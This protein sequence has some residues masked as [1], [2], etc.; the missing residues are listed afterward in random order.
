M[1]IHKTEGIILSTADWSESSQTLTVFTPDRGKLSLN[2]KGSRQ[3]N[4]RRGRPLRFARLEFTCYIRE[5][6][7]SGYLSDVEPVEVFLYEKDGQLG[8][9][10]F[11]S[12]AVELLNRLL[13]SNDPQ[14]VCYQITLSFLRMTDQLEKKRL[15]GLFTGYIL[16]LISLLG[17]RPNLVGCV[18]CGKEISETADTSEKD[19][20]PIMVS[21]ERGGVVCEECRQSMA[22]QNHLI[23]LAPE[24]HRRM[25][26]LMSSSL[27]EASRQIIGLAELNRLVDLTVTMLKYHAGTIRQLRSFDFLDKLARAVKTYGG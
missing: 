8:R 27:E 14:P 6:S 26:A 13:T 3:L 17:F 11:A 2:V 18:G 1:A 15:P 12:A 9:L 5:E 20:A 24:L 10:T 16:R 23:G 4:G 21:V 22:G 19:T 7:E 25:V